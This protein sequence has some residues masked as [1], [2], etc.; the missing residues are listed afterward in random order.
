MITK[1]VEYQWKNHW[2]VH[3]ILKRMV[4]LIIRKNELYNSIHSSLLRIN[5]VII[6]LVINILINLHRHW[7]S[8]RSLSVQRLKRMGIFCI[9][10]KI[11]IRY[12]PL[13][14]VKRS[15]W[16]ISSPSVD[17]SR[18]RAMAW[19]IK[20]LTKPS[21]NSLWTIYTGVNLIMSFNPRSRHDPCSPSMLMPM[22][23]I[24]IRR[25]T[26]RNPVDYRR[27]ANQVIHRYS[28]NSITTTTIILITHLQ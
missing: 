28:T 26:W 25:K 17:R 12:F 2:M 21:K 6:S 11:F 7:S 1:P 13:S 14:S 24:M 19:I 9:R 16:T 3:I 5:Q 27:H 8:K 20:S 15:V 22:N 10:T 4:S 23:L 18:P